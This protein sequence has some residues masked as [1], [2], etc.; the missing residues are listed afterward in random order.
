VL[1]LL[2]SDLLEVILACLEGGAD[3]Q[4]L[5]WS[6]DTA[7]DVVLAAAG[8]P[9]SPRR[10]DPITGVATVA[11]MPGVLVFH[12]GTVREQGTLKTGGGRV[13]NVVGTAGTL[14]EARRRAYAAVEEIRYKGK[15]YRRDIA[16]LAGG[17]S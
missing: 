8:Y 15:Q 2:N 5:S 17:V 4:D 7:V 10:G 9:E 11:E 12:A 3:G 14:T 6:D 13:L 1:P 16:G